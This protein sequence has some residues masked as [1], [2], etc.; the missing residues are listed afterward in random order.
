M[1]RNSPKSHPVTGSRPN[2]GADAKDHIHR[3]SPYST[4]VSKKSSR[5]TGDLSNSDAFSTEWS[6]TNEL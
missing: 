3:G 2:N 4:T 5:S 6:S 1:A